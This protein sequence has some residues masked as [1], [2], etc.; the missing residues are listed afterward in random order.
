MLDLYLNLHR[1]NAQ[2]FV[3]LNFFEMKK[4]VMFVAVATMIAFASCGNKSEKAEAE[5][6]AAATEEVAPVAEEEVVVEEV[7]D[8]AAVTADSAAVVEEAV[9]AEE[10]VAE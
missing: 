4:L 1:F 7:V 2:L 9:V 10:V 3:H 5:E 8:S 6:A